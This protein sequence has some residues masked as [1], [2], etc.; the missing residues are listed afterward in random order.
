MVVRAGGG[1]GGGEGNVCSAMPAMWSRDYAPVLQIMPSKRACPNTLPQHPHTK[2]GH[3]R[4]SDSVRDGRLACLFGFWVLV[5]V[6]DANVTFVVTVHLL[7]RAAAPERQSGASVEALI[8]RLVRPAGMKGQ[9]ASV[10]ID[11]AVKLWP[12]L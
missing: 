12:R 1:G 5:M 11:C 3:A 6:R 8:V 7:S 2:P 10:I 4:S 9:R